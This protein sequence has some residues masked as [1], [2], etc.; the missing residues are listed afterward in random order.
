M[1]VVL[2]LHRIQALN[3]MGCI[4]YLSVEGNTWR[5]SDVIF[6]CDFVD[7]HYE[8]LNLIDVST[9]ARPWS[10]SVSTVIA[11]RQIQQHF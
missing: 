9:A 3:L 10:M 4:V 7:M 2:A 6:E 5:V 8:N 11:I 1:I